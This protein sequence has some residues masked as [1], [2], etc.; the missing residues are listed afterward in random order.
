[1]NK[2]ENKTKDSQIKAV[3]NY[4]K[5]KGNTT[6]ACKVTTE[7]KTEIERHFREKGYRSFNE[8]LLALIESDML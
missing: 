5:R 1:M 3:V 7:Y 6:I 2:K 8:Y 4:D